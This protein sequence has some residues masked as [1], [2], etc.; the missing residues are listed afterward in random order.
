MKLLTVAIPCYNS[1]GYMSHAIETALV[2]GEDVE[3][4][5]VD[6]GS[7][8]D[9]PQIA[10]EYARKYPNI[11]RVIHQKNAGHGGA[12]N[13]GLANATGK[14]FKVLDSDDWFDEDSFL[15]V[16]GVIRN[17]SYAGK[18][19]DMFIT[20][21][22]YE[23]V[24]LHKSKVIRY[25]NVL[26]VN[27]VFR[28][29]DVG[30]FLP[31]QNILMH[32]VTYRT[33][34]LK[35]SGMKLPEHTFYVDNLFV[36]L[37]LPYVQTMFYLPVDMYRYYIGRSDQS[38]NE[39]VMIG[40]IDQQIAVNKLM[41]DDV[42]PDELTSRGLLRYMAKYLGMICIVTSS[43][44][45]KEGSEESIIKRDDLWE[46]FKE[47]NPDMYDIVNKDFINKTMQFKTG[48]GKNIVKI[49]YGIARKVYGF[50]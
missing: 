3:I 15:T 41:I 1:Q 31:S 28:W 14:Y 5:I 25:T 44:L 42:K 46:Y 9:T 20:N 24:H 26:P 6:D 10:D 43:L 36:Y 2:G 27:K 30:K 49:G 34:M 50:N 13:T 4:I 16:L 11:V 45:I 38:V 47:E 23:K 29:D 35:E 22:V 18:K 12:V 37:P 32:S 48:I 40:R 8:D 39:S 17:I 7:T 19:V 33:K 21:Y